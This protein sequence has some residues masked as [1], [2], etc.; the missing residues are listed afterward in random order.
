MTD[1]FELFQKISSS[2][3]SSA[4]PVTHLVVGLGNPGDEYVNTRHNTG[5]LC[6]DTLAERAGARVTT[7]KFE[8]LTGYAVLGG[9]RVLLM[10]PQTYMN[11][12]GTAV[13][14]AASYYHI[15]PEHILVLCD[16]VSFDVGHIRIRLK[17]SAGG[18]NGLKNIEA[19]LGSQNYI[20]IKVGVGKKPT[21]EMDLADF[22]LGKFPRQDLET[23]AAVRE[24]VADAVALLLEGKAD[25]AMSLYS[26]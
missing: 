14:A 10:K 21:P 25:Q 18:H 1:I 17:G 23:L 13:E 26:T 16:D 8:S 9:K 20:R 11:L 7:L 6:L 4:G 19:H 12:S 3:A 15:P 5:F 24:R 2:P 22:V